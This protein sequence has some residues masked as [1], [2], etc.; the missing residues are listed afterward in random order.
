MKGEQNMTEEK[1]KLP[2]S[3]YEELCKIIQAYGRLTKPGSLDE[4]NSLAGVGKTTVSANNLFLSSI[5]LIE[6]GKAKIPTVRG[7]DLASAIAHEISDEIQKQ[8]ALV[9]QNNEFLHKMALAVRIRKSMEGSAL[10]AHIAYSA[11]EA[12]SSEVKTGARTVINILRAAGVVKEQDGQLVYSGLESEGE[13]AEPS[14]TSVAVA[15]AKEKLHATYPIAV[16]QFPNGATV[17]ISVRI[18]A[19]PSELEG[20]GTKIRTLLR[21]IEGRDGDERAESNATL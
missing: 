17:Q 14:I 6:G 1:V 12:K 10:E 18:D 7:R 5:G 13:E 21:E 3:S 19:K 4:V 15:R 20:L 16:A 9:V 11:G 8:W 2:R